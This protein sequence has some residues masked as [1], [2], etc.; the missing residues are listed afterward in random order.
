MNFCFMSTVF[1]CEALEKCMT[2]QPSNSAS[3]ALVIEFLYCLL[4]HVC[5]IYKTHLQICC[6]PLSII[7]VEIEWSVKVLEN[8]PNIWIVWEPAISP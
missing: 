8:V 5:T 4:V 2:T 3:I 1:K 7:G 6:Q